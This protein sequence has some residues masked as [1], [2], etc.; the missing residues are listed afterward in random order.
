MAEI[1]TYDA[2]RNVHRAEKSQ[3]ALQ[4]LP[5]NFF[6]LAKAWLEQK[7]SLARKD[8]L[9]L[10]EIENAKKL[11]D[12]LVNNRERKI[13]IAA[14]NTVK[15]GLP[16]DNMTSDEEKFFDEMVFTLKNFK[17]NIRGHFLGADS[18]VEEKINSVREILSSAKPAEEVRKI[19]GEKVKYTNEKTQEM[20]QI[21]I[22][23]E[24]PK[25]VG[26]D[27]KD[28]GPYRVGDLAELPQHLAQILI[29]RGVA[30][31]IQ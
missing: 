23:Y 22:T 1:I 31:K 18:L 5:E 21:K 4:K 7:Q 29:S 13:V 15:G 30:E 3:L 26:S 19:A 16:P 28:Y 17:Q 10:L 11:L 9:A 27:L 20:V 14:I 25:F 12:D 6:S 8:T 24:L 2:I